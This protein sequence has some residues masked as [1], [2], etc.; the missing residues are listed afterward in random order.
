LPQWFEVAVIPGIFAIRVPVVIKRTLA[1][2]DL[3]RRIADWTTE[4][5]VSLNLD[6]NRFSDSKSFLL[7]VLLGSFY[8]D[9]EFGQF[10]FFESKEFR[11]ADVIVSTVVPKLDVVF[12][13]RQLLAKLE[14]SPRA[15]ETIQCDFC[16][17]QLSSLRVSDLVFE[18]LV[19]RRGVSAAVRVSRD[20]LPIA[21]FLLV[22]TQGGL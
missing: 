4:V 6:L 9:F 10:I 12:A 21:E 5:I 7:A 11:A 8:R 19:R 1:D 18:N 17:R 15:S 20:E 13:E 2:H 14:R 3:D 16:I 22:D